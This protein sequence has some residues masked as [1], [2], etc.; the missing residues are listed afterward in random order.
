[1]PLEAR[2]YAL[3][4][5]WGGAPLGCLSEPSLQK[6]TLYVVFAKRQR[7]LVR[8]FCL[9]KRPSLRGKSARAE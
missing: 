4:L 3:L 6:G 1:M 7:F 8:G 9:I 2:W 5:S